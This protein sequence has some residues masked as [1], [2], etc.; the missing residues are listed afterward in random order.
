MIDFA[1]DS[2]QYL[3]LK[4]QDGT[5]KTQNRDNDAKGNSQPTVD[6][7]NS[8]SHVQMDD[9]DLQS[10]KIFIKHATHERKRNKKHL[11]VG[12]LLNSFN[13]IMTFCHDVLKRKKVVLNWNK[14]N[15]QNGSFT[16]FALYLHRQ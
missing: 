15:G 4:H 12:L 6:F 7:Q 16:F 1:I 8:L 3:V 13:K 2:M 11:Q 10:Y 5:R 9:L 14:D